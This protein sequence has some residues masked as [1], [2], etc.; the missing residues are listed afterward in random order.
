[1]GSGTKS[2]KEL[3]GRWLAAAGERSGGVLYALE[4][5]GKTSYV[6]S[7]VEEVL[8]RPVD[9]VRHQL[10]FDIVHPEDHEALRNGLIRVLHIDEEIDLEFRVLHGDGR[11]LFVEA[12]AVRAEEEEGRQG[13]LLRFRDVTERKRSELELRSM[14]SWLQAL[15]RNSGDV[16]VVVGTDHQ[17]RFV[18]GGSETVLG[19]PPD[20]LTRER[21]RDA[22]HPSDRVAA[23]FTFENI[24]QQ[25]GDQARIEYRMQHADGR[26][27]HVETL[28]VNR[29][30]DPDVEGLILYTRDV[31]ER[32]IRDDLTGLPNKTLFIDRLQEELTRPAAERGLFAVALVRLDRHELVRT[33]L[34]PSV[35]DRML[36]QFA[37][38]LGKAVNPDW[39]VARV[40][41]ADFAVLLLGLGS[42][43]AANRAA[44]ELGQ[45]L[46]EPFH[47]SGQEVFSS[48]GM[49]L[50]LSSRRYDRADAMLRDAGGALARGQKEPEAKVANTEVIESQSN[51]LLMES[52]LVGALDRKE[53]RVWYQ[54]I[55]D[56]TSRAVWGTEALARWN[57][58]RDGMIAPG[59]FIPV[60]EETGLITSIGTWVLRRSCEQ[61]KRW[62]DR[63]PGGEALGISVN[64]S[65]R[66]LADEALVDTVAAAIEMAGIEPGRLQLEV[67][68]SGLIER[69][70]LA[71]RILTLLK[72][73]GVHLALDDFGTGYSSLSYLASFPLD[74]IKIDR[75]FVSGPRGMTVSRKGRE[76]VAAIIQLGHSLGMKVVGEGIETEEQAHLL[77]DLGCDLGQGYHLGRPVGPKVIR[78]K[79][80]FR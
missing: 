23:S 6:S 38:R 75:S 79:L 30:D 16:I 48:V 27:I 17:H 37:R 29:I 21:F 80:N 76:L 24:R 53:F 66:Q 69:P 71:A 22:I 59:R 45:A 57:H 52:D 18:S 58:P 72:E 9:E 33:I 32:R 25:P 11:T 68:E 20:E 1:M 61:L 31:T 54:P 8:G 65:A 39:T 47:L 5:S 49:G 10:I 19:I 14:V 28:A 73:Q 7:S 4:P 77:R 41:E 67:T 36:V 40:G 63:I 64:L 3:T 50:A 62:S 12:T 15:T 2:T 55:E 60:A 70:G 35:A 74:V 46:S 51:R 56:L 26:W 78:Q 34:G 44:Q 43:A 13:I 42:A